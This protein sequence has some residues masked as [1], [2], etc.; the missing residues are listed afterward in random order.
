MFFIFFIP[1]ITGDKKYINLTIISLFLIFATA[2]IV[3]L[4]RMPLIIFLFSIVLYFFLEK[5]IK[6]I[7]YVLTIFF[8]LMATFINF[9]S[10]KRIQINTKKF[11]KEVTFFVSHAPNLFI[12]NKNNTNQKIY[13][14]YLILFNSGVQLWKENKLF[15]QGIKSFRVKCKQAKHETCGSHPHNYLIELM[16]DVGIVGLVSWYLIIILSI[17]NFLK[18]YIKENNFIHKLYSSPFFLLIFTEFFPFRS[19]GSFFTTGNSAFI[20]LILAIFL[21]LNKIKKI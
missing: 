5:K 15:G 12:H 13:S 21:N 10:N 2:I 11:V 3:T 1:I 18:Y 14:D 17:T 7:L 16:V 9:S 8:L 4:N 19:S 20:F 6:E